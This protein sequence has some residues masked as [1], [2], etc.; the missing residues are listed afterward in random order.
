MIS[1][2]VFMKHADKVC[3]NSLNEVRPTLSGVKHL[4]NGDAVCTD[5][6]RLY[7]AKGIHDRTD[8]AVITPAGK[9][10]DGNYPDVSRIIPDALY[11]KQSLQIEVSE[12]LRAS[13]M[14]ASVG[15]VA[16]KNM[17]EGT[18]AVLKP[19]ALEFKEDAIQYN[20]FAV[21]IKYSIFPMQFE[22]RIC[23]NAVYLLDALKLLKAAGCQMVTLNFYGTTRPFT[24]VNEDE[25]LLALI[26]PIRKY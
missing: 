16:Q 15:G 20:N 26:L 1:Y 17:V 3:K 22:E 2:E 8:G 11:A 13:D 4:E 7:L 9:K 18:E 12:L 14:I 6:H 25:S 23:A 5:S 24:L 19:P 10:V 21:K